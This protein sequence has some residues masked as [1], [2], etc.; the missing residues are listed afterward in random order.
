MTRYFSKNMTRRQFV[1]AASKC[2]TAACALA[3]GGVAATQ[4]T[5]CSF[6]QDALSAVGI[7]GQN[8][9]DKTAATTEAPVGNYSAQPAEVDS[10]TLTPGAPD[11]A[12]GF[13]IDNVLTANIMDD[14]HFCLYVPATYDGQTALPLFI[15]LS[16]QAG[17]YAAGAGQNLASET[18]A[19]AAVA[20]N[21]GMIV[22][23]PQFDTSGQAAAVATVTLTQ[24]LESAYNINRQQIFI[25]GY[26]AG[27]Q[28]LA[29][30]L[31]RQ[32]Q[33]YAAALFCAGTWDA[34]I[35]SLVNA[36]VPVYMALA[37]GDTVA[38]PAGPKTTASRLREFYKIRA[39]SDDQIA[40]LVTYDLKD[41]DYF[42]AAGVP[43][44]GAAR[45][46]ALANLVAADSQIMGWL[47]DR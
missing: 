11:A 44:D 45:H 26:D 29:N 40:R 10:Y 37:E 21:P 2:A 7:G 14:L 41:A 18:F 42:A 25:E 19:T 34:G 31:E 28:T 33:L 23:A 17:F 36:Q 27:A 4:L 6:V 9:F 38:D 46:Q 20:H 13:T 3:A 43:D 47:L 12:T 8:V 32:P 1:R 16:G 30:V 5:G 35:D 39:L 24:W 22:A 15:T